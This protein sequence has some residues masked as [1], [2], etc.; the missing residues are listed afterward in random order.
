M[1]RRSLEYLRAKRYHLIDLSE[2]LARLTG[3]GEPIRGAV[4][5]TIDDGYFDQATVAAPLFAEY[6]CPVTT[7]VVTGFLDGEIWFWWDQITYAL[8]HTERRELAVQVGETELRYSRDE[9]D[10]WTHVEHDFTE[11][12]KHVPD[13]V[14][15]AAVSSLAAAAEVDLPERAPPR[16]GPMSWDQVRACEARGMSFGPHSVTHPILSQT[17]DTNSRRELA[18]SWERLRSEARRPVPVFC[19]PNGLPQDFGTREIEVLGRLGMQAALTAVPGYAD[20]ARIRS[21]AD[22]RFSVHR[23]SYPD[24]LPYLVQYASGM[25][26]FKQLMRGEVLP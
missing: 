5:F 15:R 24:K 25:E 3:D 6:D 16:Y 22:H 12:C 8:R 9:S 4:A 7:F 21:D 1:L 17:S 10:E 2:L 20:G 26:R 14:R 11:R 18:G 19:Y 13:A 23:Y